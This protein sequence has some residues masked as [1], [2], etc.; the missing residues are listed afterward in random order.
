MVNAIQSSSQWTSRTA[1]E[2]SKHKREDEAFSLS[3]TLPPE[4]AA[5]FEPFGADGFTPADAIDI[6]NPL[7]HLPIIG[8][9]YRDFTGD[10]LDPF[11]RIAGNTLFF[12]PL[13][14]AFSSINVAIEELTGRDIGSNVI[15]IF[16][17]ENTNNTK[18]QTA[19]TNLAPQPQTNMDTNNSV[20][21]VSFWAS[22][23]IKHRNREA[24]KQGI[25]LPVRAYSKLVESTTASIIDFTQTSIASTLPRLKE[26]PTALAKRDTSQAEKPNL[27]I[28]NSSMVVNALKNNHLASPTT[29]QQVKRTTNAYQSV[30]AYIS[31]SSSEPPTVRTA[32]KSLGSISTSGEWFSSFLNGALSK[33]HQTE[34]SK[35]LNNKSSG[36]FSLSLRK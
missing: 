22:N 10:K 25:N 33:Y 26:L 8:P 14:A 27:L 1:H 2:G 29:L 30:T 17:E 16:K 7:Q 11:S 23:E 3:S 15:A 36:S 35:L 31:Q 18:S 12:G 20:D 28:K 21:P 19:S 34:H 24:L 9:L 5:R 32:P 6:V 13:G 4:K